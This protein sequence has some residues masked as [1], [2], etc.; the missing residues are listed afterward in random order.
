MSFQFANRI[1]G[2]K[3]SAVREILKVTADPTFIPFAAGNPATEAFPVGAINQIT[4][5]ILQNGPID[6][7]QYS[8]SEGYLPLRKNI[9]KVILNK[10][11]IVKERDEIVITSGA[12]QGIELTCKVFCNEGDVI[13]CENPSF[14]GSLN[15]FRSYGIRLVGVEME[16]DGMDLAQLETALQNNPTTKLIYVIPNFQNPTGKTMS[17]AKRK[18]VLALAKQYDV[19]ILEDNPYGDLRFAGE[20]VPSIKS[21]D[22]DG[23]V[24]YCGSFSKI[25]APGLRVGYVVADKEIQAKIT[26]GKQCSDV[27]TAIFNQMICNKFLE[28]YDFEAH[29][30]KL[31]EIYRRK[32]TLMLDCLASEL[33]PAI[34]YT[35]PQGGLFIWG[36]LP[37]GVDMQAFCM[38]GVE[39]KVAVV[40]GVAFLPEEGGAS[41][42]FRLNFSTP[43][44][45][46]IVKGVQI[47][48]EISKK[49]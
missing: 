7:L 36:T 11:E 47:L 27:H 35:K 29:L 4:A 10:E 32:C 1:N 20:P 41:Q 45:D 33:N 5:E 34:T 30:E 28:Q 19:I 37:E 13:V 16:E 23:R 49:L 15:S 2:M 26:I 14:I 42:S 21:M 6:A 9:Q 8:I 3:P 31:R 46:S 22:T 39:R 48:G 43:S 40:P 18:A 17:L 24:V 25:L 12:Q 38:A 44:D